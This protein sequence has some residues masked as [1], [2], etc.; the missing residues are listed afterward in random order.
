[1]SGKKKTLCEW[2]KDEL[3]ERIKEY[4]KL[5]RDAA[6]VCRKCGRAANDSALLCKP[7]KLYK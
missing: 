1:M 6:F 3:K 5:V 7:V 4:K 2:D